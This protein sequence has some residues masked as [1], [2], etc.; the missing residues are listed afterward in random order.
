M[1]GRTEVFPSPIPVPIDDYATMKAAYDSDATDEDTLYKK[2]IFN[3]LLNGSSRTQ[4]LVNNEIND[5]L[6]D[7][8]P[9]LTKSS[10]V[11]TIDD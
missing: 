2:A 3:E 6:F 11:A 4:T 1:P 7:V 8:F 10:E 5:Y 9:T